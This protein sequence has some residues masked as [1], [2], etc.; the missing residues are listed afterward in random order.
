MRGERKERDEV[1]G[2]KGRWMEGFGKEKF[3]GR[4]KDTEER[5]KEI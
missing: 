5:E 1:S 3:Q 4:G 2:R